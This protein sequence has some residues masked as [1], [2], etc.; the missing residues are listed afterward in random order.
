MESE[1]RCAAW[2]HKSERVFAYKTASGSFDWRANEQA[3]PPPVNLQSR[4]SL[5]LH[6]PGGHT[7]RLGFSMLAVEPPTSSDHCQDA[8]FFPAGLRATNKQI[9]ECRGVEV[10]CSSH[11]RRCVAA[12]W[13]GVD[14][15]MAQSSKVVTANGVLLSESLLASGFAKCL[16]PVSA[17]GGKHGQEGVKRIGVRDGI[18]GVTPLEIPV[19]QCKLWQLAP[20]TSPPVPPIGSKNTQGRRP[21]MEDADTV[22]PSL[23]EVPVVFHTG[24]RIVPRAVEKGLDQLFEDEAPGS[25]RTPLARFPSEQSEDGIRGSRPKPLASRPQ[26]IES[27][28]HFA[29]VY[30][31]HGGQMVSREVADRL[32]ILVAEAFDVIMRSSSSVGSETTI[33][34]NASETSHWSAHPP[35][36][37]TS[38][39]RKYS[40][41][42]SSESSNSSGS[43]SVPS[44][45]HKTARKAGEDEYASEANPNSMGMGTLAAFQRRMANH[46]M[47]S[48]PG[49]TLEQVAEAL[50]LAFRWMDEEL[51]KGDDARNVGS[52]AVVAMVSSSHICLANCGDSRAVLSRS[53]R[54]YRLTRDHK[55]E[56][57]DE[58]ERIRS[59]GG[60]ILDFNGKRVMGL[61]AMSRAFGDHCLRDVGVVAD[62]EITIIDR[63]PEDEFVVLASDGLWDAL[64]DAEV[65]DLATRCFRRAKERG[66]APDTAARVAAS[67]LMKAALDR[68]SNDNITVVV[69][70][71]HRGNEIRS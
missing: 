31:G 67:V 34:S 14:A 56:M 25:P 6:K 28:F 45:T 63:T 66:A 19:E 59:C 68:G 1:T 16:Y 3:I 55:P 18:L 8:S 37:A 12:Q 2:E 13:S 40:R 61:L 51:L 39:K 17:D 48:H 43:D 46:L 70:D 21:R 15:N 11:W 20:R 58:Q 30:D 38:L 4:R 27:T 5:N 26:R 65:C 35:A 64:S 29:G 22:V 54:A 62:P 57:E 41:R 23:V 71:L 10:P 60:R 69:V 49:V 52:T 24:E 50:R 42:G 32:H 7:D 47:M 36:A 53:G 9:G 33:D 44:P